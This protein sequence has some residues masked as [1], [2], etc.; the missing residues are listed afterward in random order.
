V[1]GNGYDPV[2]LDSY[3]SLW[4]PLEPQNSLAA[5]RAHLNVG[6]PVLLGTTVDQAFK[7]AAKVARESS[8][9]QGVVQGHQGEEDLGHAFL[10][11]GYASN[12]QLSDIDGVPDGWGGGYLI[13]KNSWGCKGDGGYMHVSDDWAVDQVHEAHAIV[14]TTT[15]ADWP[16][17]HLSVE[18]AN[19]TQAGTLRFTVGVRRATRVEIFRGASERV[20][21]LSLQDPGAQ[22]LTNYETL[23][24]SDN[25]VHIYWAQVTDQF[26]NQSISNNLAVRVNIDNVAPTVSLSAS[27]TSVVAPASIV[28]TASATD[29]T[30]VA[31][32]KF[33]R[34]LN[35]IG[36]DTTPPYSL[37]YI[38]PP[39]GTGGTGSVELS[40]VALDAAGNQKMSNIVTVQVETPPIGMGGAPKVWS[41]SAAPSQ[42]PAGGGTTVLHWNVVGAQSVKITPN[43]GDVELKGEREVALTETT[44]F[45]LEAISGAF[46]RTASFTVPV[47]QVVVAPTIASFTAIPVPGGDFTLAWDVQGTSPTLSIDQGVGDVTGTTQVTVKPTAATTYTLTAT[48]AA[49]Q[50]TK[51]VSAEPLKDAFV[52]PTGNDT[53]NACT[54]EA[55]PCRT[56]VHAAT[57]A[58]TAGRVWL[59][60]GA[61][62]AANQGAATVTVPAGARLQGKNPGVALLRVRVDINGGEVRD[63]VVDRTDNTVAGLRLVGGTVT[64]EALRF[65]GVY[66]VGAA[67]TFAALDVA[68]ATV[69]TLTP[70]TVTNYA[71]DVL[72]ST[73]VGGAQSLIVVRGTATLTIAGGTI[74][75]DGA[76]PGLGTDLAAA[77]FLVEGTA[78]LFLNDVTVRAVTRAIRTTGSGRVSLDACTLTARSVIGR[79]AYGIWANGAASTAP[80]IIVKDSTISGFIN[81]PAAIG[82]GGNSAGIGASDGDPTIS[83]VNATVTQN[84]IGIYSHTGANPTVTATNSTIDANLWGGLQVQGPMTLRVTGGSISDN[85]R[86]TTTGVSVWYGGLN[87]VLSSAHYDVRLRNV[88]VE[89]NRASVSNGSSNHPENNGISAG[90]DA[91]SIFDLGTAAMPGNNIF[92]GNRTPPQSGAPAQTHNIFVRNNVTVLAVGNTFDANTQGADA[93]GKY[94]L[95]TGPCAATSPCEITSADG[96]NYRVAAGKLRLA[97]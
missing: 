3:V 31:R 12:G 83:L 96:V 42:L 65:R 97:E 88:R 80:E 81:A 71:A 85:D 22:N 53:G 40:A 21:N 55:M 49:G 33:Y 62:D 1:T 36:Q 16:D 57:Q 18:N 27:S 11:V 6:H 63:V 93:N 5:I 15:N 35:L 34:G 68:G 75:S 39:I 76:G 30:G 23:D 26:G 82:G 84:A 67:V 32:V 47:Q 24:A 4:N 70:G 64:L 10:V 90:G 78:Q 77:A 17:V 45:Q 28:L 66:S 46:K 56:I 58:G 44:T 59:L 52:S 91:T 54:V 60:D 87:F 25:G 2:R 92:R 72:P 61:Y 13:A 73:A 79:G 51:S 37:N 48:N 86:G 38:V 94:A 89:N 7:D 74:D 50:A 69:A 43:I 29:N 95:G 8:T 19:V 20:Y 41:F 14:G 9:R